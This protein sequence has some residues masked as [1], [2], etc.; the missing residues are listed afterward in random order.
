M[1]VI[2]L[3]KI[4]AV[5]GFWLSPSDL[6]EILILGYY[7]NKRQ[8]I[9]KPP[10]QSTF[11]PVSLANARDYKLGEGGDTV[12]ATAGMGPQ[13]CTA[14]KTFV[15]AQR[16]K[17]YKTTSRPTPRAS[18]SGAGSV[19]PPPYLADEVVINAALRVRDAASAGDILPETHRRA[20]MA[21]AA[22]VYR[23]R[24]E[25]AATRPA[26]DAGGGI[27]AAA[28]TAQTALDWN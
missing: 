18:S 22:Q 28:A 19:R 2:S 16:K 20:L 26:I 1:G 8:K 6:N 23:S 3:A 5:L 15:G 27:S 13:I 10:N 4:P 24:I 17:N 9:G 7:Q 25:R 11:V 21:D 14:L 12:L